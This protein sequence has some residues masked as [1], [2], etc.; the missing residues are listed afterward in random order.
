M[1]DFQ[2]G[3]LLQQLHKEFGMDSHAKPSKKQRKE[4]IKSVICSY[5]ND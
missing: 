2:L 4:T 1:C 3:F 5:I